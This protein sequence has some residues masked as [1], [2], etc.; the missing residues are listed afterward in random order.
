MLP[1]NNST[2]I[3]AHPGQPLDWKIRVERKMAPHNGATDSF[4]Y[5]APT[6]KYCEAYT[7]MTGP[8][9]GGFVTYL[10]Y[11]HGNQPYDNLDQG[12][13]V[14]YRTPRLPAFLELKK[15]SPKTSSYGTQQAQVQISQMLSPSSTVG[16]N[17]LRTL[18]DLAAF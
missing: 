2:V 9:P 3:P 1:A 12:L 5:I 15:V 11:N 16:M 8:G 10:N 17:S 14:A 7:S 13:N 4:D 18:G 6:P